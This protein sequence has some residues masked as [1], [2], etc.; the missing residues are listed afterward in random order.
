MA[1][2]KK[3]KKQAAARARAHLH[4]QEVIL[5]TES[6]DFASEMVPESPSSVEIDSCNEDEECGWDGTINHWLSSDSS[7][8]FVWN[9]LDSE[10]ELSELEG[11]EL[12]ESLQK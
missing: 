6:Q 10:S 9:G 7:S 11:E 5:P 3:H 8:D 2:T 4:Q 1:R 12:L